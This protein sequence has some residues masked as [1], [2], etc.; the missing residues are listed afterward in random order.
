MNIHWV[1]Y[2]HIHYEL[3]SRG[4]DT[5]PNYNLDKQTTIMNL[6]ALERRSLDIAGPL[7][8]SNLISIKDE[9]K[10]QKTTTWN[11]QPPR[12][13]DSVPQNF[14]QADTQAWCLSSK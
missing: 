10:L 12:H 6:L 3:V 8:E 9:R 11:N 7:G 13:K 2:P 4:K 1:L 5:I 14:N